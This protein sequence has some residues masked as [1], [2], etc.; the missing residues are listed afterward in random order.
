MTKTICDN[1]GGPC[2]PGTTLK[3]ST[4]IDGFTYDVNLEVMA[5]DPDV[6]PGH[7]RRQEYDQDLCSVCIWRIVDSCGKE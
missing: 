6:G 1:C 5:L 3:T 2:S 7:P 4:Q